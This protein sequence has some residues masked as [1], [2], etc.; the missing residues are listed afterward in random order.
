M[1]ESN[2]VLGFREKANEDGGYING[3]FF[4]LEPEVHDYIEGDDTIWERDPMERLSGEGRLNAYRHRGFWQSMDTLRD[5]NLLEGLW[6]SG[7]APWK[8]W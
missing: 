8:I 2:R 7:D 5:R 6:Q 4:V 1:A 3:G